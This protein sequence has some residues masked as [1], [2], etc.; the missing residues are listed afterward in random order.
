MAGKRVFGRWSV[1][2]PV[3][4]A[5][6]LSGLSACAPSTPGG[7][8]GGGCT[9]PTQITGGYPTELPPVAGWFSNDTRT[10]GNVT[11]NASYGAPT[12]YGC[13]AAVMTTGETLPPGYT[14]GQDKAQLFS[15]AKFGSSFADV[16]NVSYWAYRSSAS[17]NP[18]PNMS[19]NVQL[20]GTAG[21]APGCTVEPGAPGCLTTLVYEPYNQSG[22]QAAI[23]NDTWQYWDATSSTAG[24]GKWWSTKI[25]SGPG[26]IGSPQPWSF[27]KSLYTDAVLGAYGFNIG[28]YNPNMVV[29]ADAL[30]LGTTTTDF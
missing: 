17:L 27:F 2:G 15:Y 7:G 19:L 25:P 6:L 9:P 1:A 5:V 11:V 20:Y 28:S 10:T 4:V 24:D 23:I 3:V 8:G 13:N 22:G 12:G 16:N 29:A 18:A 14:T 21:Y 30:T 26:S